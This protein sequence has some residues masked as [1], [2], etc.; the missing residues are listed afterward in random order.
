[1][2]FINYFKLV[3]TKFR[4][5]GANCAKSLNLLNANIVNIAV[6]FYGEH[7]E[8]VSTIFYASNLFR[9]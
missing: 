4:Y 2:C 9:F 3:S 6:I 7:F 8:K 5:I 1:M